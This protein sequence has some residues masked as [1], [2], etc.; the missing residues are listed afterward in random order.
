[1]KDYY[2][3]SF[4]H[5]L[6]GGLREQDVV[7]SM[8]NLLLVWQVKSGKSPNHVVSETSSVKC[9]GGASCTSASFQPLA[10]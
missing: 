3:M 10:F 5:K 9:G 7:H 8:Q 4:W 1:M 6:K 2:E